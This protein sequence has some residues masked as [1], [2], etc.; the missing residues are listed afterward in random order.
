MYISTTQVCIHFWASHTIYKVSFKF[1]SAF[2]KLR[3][4]MRVTSYLIMYVFDMG[5]YAV[6]HTYL[7]IVDEHYLRQLSIDQTAP[8]GSTV[9]HSNAITSNSCPLLQINGAR[10]VN[11]RC[12][13]H[14]WSIMHITYSPRCAPPTNKWKH[15]NYKTYIILHNVV[16]LNNNYDFRRSGLRN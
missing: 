15:N 4:C 16:N 1:K 9:A 5:S 2:T 14:V 10:A 6:S 11:D 7:W 12:N 8:T 3:T 13:I